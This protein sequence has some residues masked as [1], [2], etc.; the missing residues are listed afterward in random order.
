[1]ETYNVLQVDIV[2]G[3]QIEGVTDHISYGYHIR[4]QYD[5]I[6]AQSHMKS[7]QIIIWSD[8]IA[9]SHMKSYE[10]AL[11]VYIAKWTM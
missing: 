8:M 11:V 7:Y 5:L 6:W 2:Y 1:M 3:A 10:N 9:P 4:S